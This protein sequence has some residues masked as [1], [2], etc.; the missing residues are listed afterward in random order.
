MLF[1]NSNAKF[2]NQRAMPSGL[3]QG[4]A[5]SLTLSCGPAR[6]NFR[7][8]GPQRGISPPRGEAAGGLRAPPADLPPGI[9][10]WKV[11]NPGPGDGSHG[12][13]SKGEKP[14]GESQTTY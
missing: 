3:P 4:V 1:P 14:L 2:A 5:N 12:G 11:R 13:D 8:A 7:L 10:R 9:V 6:R